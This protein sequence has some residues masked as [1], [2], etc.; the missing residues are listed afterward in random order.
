MKQPDHDAVT[1]RQYRA[2][3]GGAEMKRRWHVLSIHHAWATMI[4]TGQKT[5]ET[6]TWPTSYRGDLVMASTH[7]PYPDDPGPL[8]GFAFAIV[9]LAD[10][11]LMT[12]ADEQAACS[13]Y[14]PGLFAWVLT[15]PRPIQPVYVKGKQRIWYLEAEL[16]ER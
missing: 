10:C 4:A 3:N 2:T 15:D 7:Q 11:R 13:D 6:R 5:I 12:A 8:R 16:I 1:C 9:T 14:V